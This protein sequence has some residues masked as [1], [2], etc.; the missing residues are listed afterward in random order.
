MQLKSKINMLQSSFESVTEIIDR[1][2]A[3]KAGSR[4]IDDQ[5]LT[6][7]QSLREMALLEGTMQ[8]VAESGKDLVQRL[9][10]KSNLAKIT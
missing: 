2:P 7:S 6:L 10:D 3:S 8:K 1:I 9:Q 5:Y 4:S